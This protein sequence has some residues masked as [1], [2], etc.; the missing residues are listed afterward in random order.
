MVSH[1]A[2]ALFILRVDWFERSETQRKQSYQL[3]A[4]RRQ[5]R[6]VELF[7]AVSHSAFALFILRIGWFERS[8]TQRKQSYQISD[9]RLDWWGWFVW[10]LTQHSACS[11]FG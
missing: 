11:F 8:E 7:C 4:F 5:I 3:S 1:S 9:V 2:F 6:L 10:Y